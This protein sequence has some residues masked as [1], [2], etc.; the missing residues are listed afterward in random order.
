MVK[1]D[2]VVVNEIMEKNGYTKLSLCSVPSW[3]NTTTK[4]G[5]EYKAGNFN[6]FKAVDGTKVYPDKDSMDSEMIKR[7]LFMSTVKPD[8][9]P[10]EKPKPEDKKEPSNVDIVQHEE[11]EHSVDTKFINNLPDVFE[12]KR[13]IAFPDIEELKKMSVFDRIL[14]F[15]KTYPKFIKYLDKAHERPYVEGN[16]MKQEANIAFL[17]QWSSKIDGWNLD[18]EAVA[19]YGSIK[20]NIDGKDIIISGVGVDKQVYRKTDNQPTLTIPEMMKNACTD[21]KKKC[22]ADMGFNGDVY[23]GE[24]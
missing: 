15:Q 23:R 13:I 14:L 4:E 11:K 17:F 10:E 18:K 1:Y 6:T 22:L 21:M 20:V 7:E 9:K 2:I 12:G 19:C 3:I 24:V 8:V 5:M 16:I